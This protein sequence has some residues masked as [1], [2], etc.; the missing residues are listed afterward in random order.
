[1]NNEECLS[2]QNIPASLPLPRALFAGPNWVMLGLRNWGSGERGRRDGGCEEGEH[3]G[4]LKR[5]QSSSQAS[6]LL[7]REVSCEGDYSVCDARK[8]ST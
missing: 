2:L 4:G 1:M 8:S 5:N 7:K 3:R 6:F